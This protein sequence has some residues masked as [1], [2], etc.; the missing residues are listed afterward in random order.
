MEVLLARDQRMLKAKS[1]W[2][3]NGVTVG[4][5]NSREIGPEGW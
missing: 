1:A 5:K 3:E 2:D 4:E